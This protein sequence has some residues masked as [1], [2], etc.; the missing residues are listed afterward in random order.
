M[1]L[2]EARDFAGLLGDGETHRWPCGSLVL[3]TQFQTH[4]LAQPDPALSSD[5]ALVL[6]ALL[7]SYLPPESNPFQKGHLIMANWVSQGPGEEEG[8]HT[9]LSSL[10]VSLRAEAH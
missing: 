8:I 1:E 9:P 5:R 7:A 4:T 6:L 3:I 10:G 2:G